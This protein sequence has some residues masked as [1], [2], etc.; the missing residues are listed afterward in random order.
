MGQV[1]SSEMMHRGIDVECRP[2]DIQ[3]IVVAQVQ[4]QQTRQSTPRGR[5]V[6]TPRR[7]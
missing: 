4:R 7:I 1:I 3:G 2:V 6:E 5:M